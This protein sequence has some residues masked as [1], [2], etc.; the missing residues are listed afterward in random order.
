MT[1]DERMHAQINPQKNCIIYTLRPCL[2]S[3]DCILGHAVTFDLVF[4]VRL[5]QLKSWD[6]KV[7]MLLLNIEYGEVDSYVVIF[8]GGR[9][10]FT[11]LNNIEVS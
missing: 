3:V 7:P 4:F 8:F 5:H 10:N 1:G 2:C 6:A 9:N 11:G